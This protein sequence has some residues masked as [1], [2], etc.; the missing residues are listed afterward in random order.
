MK[1]SER[2]AQEGRWIRLTELLLKHPC[3]RGTKD[4]R[5]IGLAV[6][7]HVNRGDWRAAARLLDDGLTQQMPPRQ[8]TD[9]L[10]RVEAEKVEEERRKKGSAEHATDAFNR[11]TQQRDRVEI[12]G[13]LSEAEAAVAERWPFPEAQWL[14]AGC[15]YDMGR[16]EEAMQAAG[17]ARYEELVAAR[18]VVRW[19]W[20]RN[21]YELKST[22]DVLNPFYWINGQ[23]LTFACGALMPRL[24]LWTIPT[25]RRAP[26]QIRLDAPRGINGL[27]IAKTPAWLALPNDSV[28]VL[29]S[30]GTLSRSD[31]SDSRLY[32]NMQ[33]VVPLDSILAI[34][35]T[36]DFRSFAYVARDTLFQHSLEDG[37]LERRLT[38]PL[39]AGSADVE[40]RIAISRSGVIKAQM[41][42]IWKEAFWNYSSGQRV[43]PGGEVGRICADQPSQCHEMTFVGRTHLAHATSDGCELRAFSTG[44]VTAKLPYPDEA[45]E[46]ASGNCRSI[47][48]QGDATSL[49]LVQKS[50]TEGTSTSF[51]KFAIYLVK[52]ISPRNLHIRRFEVPSR[53]FPNGHVA[54][55]TVS[56]DGKRI[57]ALIEGPASRQ[58]VLVW[59][60]SS[61]AVLAEIALSP[62]VLGVSAVDVEGSRVAAAADSTVLSLD[63]ARRSRYARSTS[64]I[65]DDDFRLTAKGI[66]ALGRDGRAFL[67]DAERSQEVPLQRPLIL[68]GSWACERNSE[69]CLDLDNP[70]QIR[71]INLDGLRD[72]NL[73]SLIS[74]DGRYAVLLVPP[75]QV[76]ANAQNSTVRKTR[77]ES[78]A[79]D[80]PRGKVRTVC[81]TELDV[82]A[83]VQGGFGMA[84]LTGP[85]TSYTVRFGS[86]E[87]VQNTSRR[88]P[89]RWRVSAD[90]QRRLAAF[91]ERRL[92]SS[93]GQ[94]IPG[95]LPV[96]R[97]EYFVEPR[98]R[99]LGRGFS[100]SPSLELFDW[101]GHQ[102]LG[103]FYPVHAGWVY[104][105]LP[106]LEETQAVSPVSSDYLH[107]ERVA[108]VG[109]SPNDAL[110]CN[111]LGKLYPWDLCADVFEDIDVIW[112]GKDESAFRMSHEELELPRF[113]GQER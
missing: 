19:G 75:A 18:S 5:S 60:T 58:Q 89:D 85:T 43:H 4:P 93:E 51:S 87:V 46:G 47:A 56:P 31:I 55:A 32:W 109:D 16:R 22:K 110:S 33:P 108:L 102:L 100:P 59:D 27:P 45:T 8:R 77:V 2:L 40:R 50:R 65:I 96:L 9:L 95:Q 3:E 70:T 35:P 23:V 67:I 82:T 111:V 76:R 52:E 101:N 26:H 103:R 98:A 86:C 41:T 84:Y 106:S 112:R 104:V 83:V 30:D 57:G 64:E 79:L 62:E 63:F 21:P 34:V 53:S 37:R 94:L 48:E 54:A 12:A 66:F 78:L 28:L 73:R 68:L 91:G 44:S 72:P 49:V 92:Y 88:Q 107:T 80:L 69:R 61:E 1:E 20:A 81:A 13:C 25:E 97:A 15:L 36:P 38:L 6:V 17:R 29:G 99:L 11:G 14:R 24:A 71:E 74:E 90:G 113:L 105:D 7:A 39:D 42:T 10:N